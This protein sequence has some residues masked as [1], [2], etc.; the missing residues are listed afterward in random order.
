[1]LEASL[2]GGSGPAAGSGRGQPAPDGHEAEALV[3]EAEDVGHGTNIVGV[4]GRSVMAGLGRVQVVKAVPAPVAPAFLR[5]VLRAAAGE[6]AVA[7]A[8]SPAGDAAELTV[9]ITG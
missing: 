4:R 7:A 9:R 3:Y 6:P 1:M 5:G 8:L 2:P